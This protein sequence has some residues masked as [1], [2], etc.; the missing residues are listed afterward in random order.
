MGVVEIHEN[1]VGER[2]REMH[3]E[4]RRQIHSGAVIG[5]RIAFALN[6]SRSHDRTTH[7]KPPRATHKQQQQTKSHRTTPSHTPTHSHTH[8]ESLAICKPNSR[9]LQNLAFE[10]NSWNNY[11]FQ[12]ANSYDSILEFRDRWIRSN[13]LMKSKLIIQRLLAKLKWNPL[14]FNFL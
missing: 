5:Q 9:K 10:M 4:R 12:L 7:S 8:T 3:R 6:R 1:A 11:D 13:Y 14:K 2:P